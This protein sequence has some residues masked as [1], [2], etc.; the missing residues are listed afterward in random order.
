MFQ[1]FFAQKDKSRIGSE[2]CDHAVSSA[3]EAALCKL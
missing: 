3:G 1:P 2:M